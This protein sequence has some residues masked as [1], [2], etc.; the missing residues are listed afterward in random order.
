MAKQKGLD[1]I[2]V[3]VIRNYFL[4][5]AYQMRST[6]IRASFNPVIYEMVDFSVGLYDR[7]AQLLAE[8]PGIPVFMGTLTYSIQN[9][10][11]YLGEENIDD[12][13]KPKGFMMSNFTDLNFVVSEAETVESPFDFY[14]TYSI[15]KL[16][17][18]YEV[19]KTRP[20]AAAFAPCTF[21]FYKLKSEEKIVM[22]FP[23]IYNW[24]S[25]AYIEDEEA[26]SQL[27]QAQK[28]FESIMD[29]ATK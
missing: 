3:E 14:D 16:E 20:E 4:S 23:G 21:M 19:I 18:L 11:K 17:V 5:S 7:E 26:K 28:D 9:C 22:G 10:V 1:P 25:S 15:C 6:L 27:I 8:G 12:G 13:L 24:M 29:E 2:T